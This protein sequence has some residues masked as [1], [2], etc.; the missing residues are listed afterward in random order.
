MCGIIAYC[1]K[2]LA[3]PI[4]LTGLERLEYRGYD[5][6]GVALLG[7]ETPIICKAAGKLERLRNKL[8]RV[9]AY[10]HFGLAHTRWATHGG[11]TTVNAHPHTSNDGD[12]IGVH[13]G[14]IENYLTL[15]KKLEKSGYTFSSATDTEVLI[16]FIDWIRENEKLDLISALQ[17]ALAEV[18]G[19]CVLVLYSRSENKMIAVNKGGQLFAGSNGLDCFIASDKIAFAGQCENFFEIKDGQFL[20][21]KPN[22]K[23][24]LL[25]LNLDTLMP[26]L[27]KIN[28][29]IR[30]LDL[31]DFPN[32]MMKEIFSQP[33]VVRDALAGRV[34]F[35]SKEFCF[36]GLAR[37]WSRFRRADSLVIVACGTSYYA[38]L[39]GKYWLEKLAGLSVKVEYASEFQAATIRQGDLVLGISQ[40]GTTADTILALKEAKARRAIVFGVCNVVGST[41]SRLTD[42]GIYTRAGVE[43]GVASTKAFT[44]Q[45]LALL[46]LTLKLA[47]DKKTMANSELK[48]VIGQ[49]EKLPSLMEEVLATSG[50]IK[51][52]AKKFRNSTNCLYLGRGCN[53]PI[54][55]EG[56]LKLKELS[57]VHAEGMPAGESK[58]GPLALIDAKMPVVILAT[59]SEF[60]GKTINNLAE[61]KARGGKV[62]VV[63]N[64]GDNQA[65]KLADESI[66]VPVV[67]EILSPI[68]NV[69]PLQLFAY[70]S[71]FLRGRDVD[72]PR[73]LAKSVTVE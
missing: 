1:G 44:A 58:H 46:L 45:I 38:G 62:I 36:G 22:Q 16:N 30:E 61:I 48:E 37:H 50:V 19:T 33:Q 9:N 56:A 15:K 5:S 47:K 54:A 24:A 66:I 17:I 49:L 39:L 72:R 55:L 25:N 51:S 52:L 3:L 69:I 2:Q 23:P 63:V 53:F 65:V 11:A 71:A 64:K 20:L 40:S 14:T 31:G 70:H 4:L 68:L 10:S 32:F 42:A 59:K 35:Q 6:A 27:E 29:D 41:L 18:V 34:D 26:H 8:K 12:L 73:N 60:Y 57:Y 21:V 67:N 28:V 13:N 43:N 7:L